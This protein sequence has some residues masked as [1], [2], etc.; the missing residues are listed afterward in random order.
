MPTFITSILN[1]DR[2]Q[3]QQ[4]LEQLDVR[5]RMEQVLVYIKKEQ[6]LLRIQKKDRH[7]RSMRKIEKS[8]REYFLREEI[9]A[10]KKELGEPVDSKSNEYLKFKDLVEKLMGFQGEVKEQVDRELEKVFPYGPLFL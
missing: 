5:A 6:D 4:I 10:I 2:S 9:K 1:I 3:Q 8:Q 7:P